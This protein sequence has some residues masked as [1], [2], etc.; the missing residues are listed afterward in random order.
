MCGWLVGWCCCLIGWLWLWLWLW[1]WCGRGCGRGV[2]CV[3]WHA[4]KTRVSIQNASMCTFKTSPC[5]A[6]PRGRFECTHGGVL[7]GHAAVGGRRQFRLPKFAHVGLSRASE[8][9]QKKP[10]DLTHFQFENKVEHGTFPI[11][12]IIRFT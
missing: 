11:P 9:H 7:D 1:S 8:V 12:L 5:A 2:A 6:A 4:E 10:L 3:V